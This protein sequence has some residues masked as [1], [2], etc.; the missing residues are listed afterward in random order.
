MQSFQQLPNYSTMQR[1]EKCH[2]LM[3]CC[4]IDVNADSVQII[5]FFLLLI[6]LRC[7]ARN[8]G[9]EFVYCALKMQKMNDW[10]GIEHVCWILWKQSQHESSMYC[11]YQ[12][13]NYGICTSSCKCGWLSVATDSRKGATLADIA[14]ACATT[15]ASISRCVNGKSTTCEG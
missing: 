13:G 12:L 2:K 1:H 9:F 6:H 10:D 5:T 3:Q 11:D 14:S 7:W 8:R 4:N 15:T